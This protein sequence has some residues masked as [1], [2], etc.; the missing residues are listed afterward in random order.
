[1]DN[2]KHY[3]IEVTRQYVEGSFRNYLAKE[4]IAY[5][6][7]PLLK[8]DIVKYDINGQLKY[9]LIKIVDESELVYITTQFP[10]D[11]D[12]DKMVYD[13]DAQ[14]AGAKPDTCKTKLKTV[15]DQAF[16]LA[17]QN[18]S[19]G[20]PLAAHV[21]TNETE[22]IRDIRLAIIRLGYDMDWL[23]SPM[24]DKSDVNPEFLNKVIRRC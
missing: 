23:E 3:G 12:W 24:R 14:Y 7:L 20:D 22:L 17:G 5:T 6:E 2:Y 16:S 8:H 18:I 13:I 9:A 4:G 11:M 19:Q 10:D 21:E 15:L 1:M